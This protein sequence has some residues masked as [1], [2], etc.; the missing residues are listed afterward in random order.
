M[1]KLYEWFFAHKLL[2]LILLVIV[3]VV[4][5]IAP[6]IESSLGVFSRDGAV[7]FLSY[8]GTMLSGLTGGA[9]TL[10][11]VWWTIKKQEEEKKMEFD[12]NNCPLLTAELLKKSENLSFNPYEEGRSDKWYLA[13]SIDFTITLKNAIP[14][15]NIH[16]L[17]HDMKST[18]ETIFPRLWVFENN[19]KENISESNDFIFIRSKIDYDPGINFINNRQETSENFINKS[20]FIYSNPFGKEYILEVTH[21]MICHAQ[22]SNCANTYDFSKDYDFVKEKVKGEKIYYSEFVSSSIIT[23]EEKIMCLKSR[24]RK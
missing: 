14:A 8:Y 24:I 10:G 9:L 4:V 19:L 18:N 21:Q 17:Y 13:Y 6:F 3:L 16:F 12:I 5:P 15:C 7:L 2:A 20:Y 1:K 22:K 23:D 11:G